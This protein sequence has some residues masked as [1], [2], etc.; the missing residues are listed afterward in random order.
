MSDTVLIVLIVAIVVLVVLW[1]F[2]SNLSSFVF[3]ARSDA[4]EAELKTHE[5]QREKTQPETTK[6]ESLEDDIS[7]NRNRLI[8]DNEVKIDVND[9]KTRVDD[10][11]AI[12]KNKIE[13]KQRKSKKRKQ[14]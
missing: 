6:S 1:I 2:R 13:I 14:Q 5:P 12:G 10:N 8:G 11:R 4:V 9:H 7:V 3:S